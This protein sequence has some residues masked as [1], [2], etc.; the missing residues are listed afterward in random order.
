MANRLVLV[1]ERAMKGPLCKASDFDSMITSKTMSLAK[2]YEI[3]YDSGNLVPTDN[4][5]VDDVY[6]A[7]FDLFCDLGALCMDTSRRIIFSEDEVKE[8]L[9]YLPT[10]V[11]VGC[12]REARVVRKRT[13]EDRNPPM[14]LGGPTGTLV[15]EGEIYVKNEQSIAQEPVVDAFQAGSLQTIW[16]E[17]ILTGSPLEILAARNAITW[18]REALERAS[19]P[20]LHIADDAAGLTSQ[21]KI[22][23][24]D[25]VRGIRPTDGIL[26]SQMNEMKVDY[27]HLSMTAFLLDYGASIYNL[28]TPII[29]GYAPG[30]EGLAI[31]TVAEHLVGAVIYHAVFHHMSHTHIRFLNNANRWGLWAEA[32][33]GQALARNTNILSFE[34]CYCS[35][36]PSTKELLYEVACDSM[37][38]SVSGMQTEGVGATGGKVPDHNTGLEVRL[39]GE[40]AHATAG[41][42]R[43]EANEILQK[44]LPKFED[45]LANPDRGK[46]FQECYDLKTIQPLQDWKSKYEEVRAELEEQGIIFS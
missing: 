6:R 37:V 17:R 24:C 31:V 33:V 18:A 43:G 22:C 13:V 32:V 15:S 20:G 29:G 4:G 3:K 30:P 7:G 8:V 10:E 14:I 40:V 23:V 39:M 45:K 11:N 1:S 28:M 5:L 25:P 2:E 36:G 26:V 12:G 27:D 46:P 21:G 41:M 38:S 34:D 16:G 19:R 44:L 35:H 42:K 9:R